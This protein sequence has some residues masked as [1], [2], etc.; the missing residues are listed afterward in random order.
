MKG[1]GLFQLLYSFHLD[2]IYYIDIVSCMCFKQSFGHNE[3]L[4]PFQITCRFDFSRYIHCAMHLDIYIFM[5]R[6]TTKE[7]YL[8]KPK[9]QVNLGRRE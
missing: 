9:R 1:K 2:Y 7:M 3:L 8:E 5:S 6:Y 4:P